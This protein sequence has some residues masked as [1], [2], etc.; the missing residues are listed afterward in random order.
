MV[1]RMFASLTVM[2]ALQIMAKR[3]HGH[4][5]RRLLND[6]TGAAAI[7]LAFSLTAVVGMAGLGTEVAAWYFTQRTMQGAAD[8]AA[9]TGAAALA[10]GTTS[11]LAGTEAKS[12]AATFNFV[13]GTA[14]ATVTVNNPPAS[15]T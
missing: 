1:L 2:H 8:T 3:T 6:R 12:V 9:I 4:W 11:T 10:A 15:G 14:N 13:D 7:T 5:V